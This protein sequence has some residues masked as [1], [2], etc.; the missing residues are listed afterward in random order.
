MTDPRHDTQPSDP[1]ARRDDGAGDLWG[2]IAGAT[3]LALIAVILI[4]GW[5]HR[6]A[7][8]GHTARHHRRSA[9]AQVPKAPLANA[10]HPSTIGAAPSTSAPVQH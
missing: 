6:Y 5:T 9:T 4:A 10:P 7:H 3:V 1:A 2:W 8:R